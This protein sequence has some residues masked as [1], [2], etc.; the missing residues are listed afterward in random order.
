MRGSSGKKKC[1]ASFACDPTPGPIHLGVSNTTVQTVV[2]GQHRVFS[3]EKLILHKYLYSFN[4]HAGTYNTIA[5]ASTANRTTNPSH[6]PFPVVNLRAPLPMPLP[7][8]FPL[9]APED[10]RVLAAART[11]AT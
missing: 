9:S 3:A 7:P 1:Q 11:Q 10:S 2:L 6:R 8:P 4:P 5:P